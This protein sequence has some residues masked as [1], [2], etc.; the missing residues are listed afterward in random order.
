MAED[1]LQVNYRA[2]QSNVLSCMLHFPSAASL[3]DSAFMSRLFIHGSEDQWSD[4][5]EVRRALAP[6]PSSRIEVIE[7]A[8]HNVVVAAAA[9]TADILLHHL[10]PEGSLA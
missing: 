5:N 9:R 7:G 3:S 10:T 4:S 1:A 6:Y 2:F 8:P